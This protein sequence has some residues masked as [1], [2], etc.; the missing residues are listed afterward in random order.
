MRATTSLR[1]SC[2]HFRAKSSAMA[3]SPSSGRPPGGDSRRRRSRNSRSASLRSSGQRGSGNSRDRGGSSILGNSIPSR[4]LRA[5][6]RAQSRMPGSPPA[7]SSAVGSIRCTSSRA[8]ALV[9]GSSLRMPGPL[10]QRRI[11]WRAQDTPGRPNLRNTGSAKAHR[12]AIFRTSVAGR[13]P[14]LPVKLV[15]SIGSP[16]QRW[17][18]NENAVASSSVAVSRLARRTSPPEVRLASS[19]TRDLRRRTA[20]PPGGPSNTQV[21]I[22]LVRSSASRGWFSALETSVPSNRSGAFLSAVSEIEVV[23]SGCLSRIHPT[24]SSSVSA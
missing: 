11:T 10:S 6:L 19:R 22:R 18:D 21:P 3:S 5:S 8:V 13:E 17:N 20:S 1:S 2:F 12:S 24:A 14:R 16:R 15:T 7:R 9:S 4:C 23:R